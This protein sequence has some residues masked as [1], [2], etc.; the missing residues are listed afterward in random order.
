MLDSYNTENIPY[1]TCAT[2]AIPGNLSFSSWNHG[3]AIINC[4]GNGLDFEG[5]A[6]NLEFQGL[7]ILDTFLKVNDISLTVNNC[8]FG[9]LLQNTAF[10]YLIHV[11]VNNPL[12]NF[13][14]YISS[15]NFLEGNMAGVLHVINYQ[16]VPL[17]VEI[18]NTTV[19]NN[20]LKGANYVIFI[21]GYVNF[22]FMNS[23]ISNTKFLETIS[24]RSLIYFDGCPYTATREAYNDTS[25]K[26]LGTKTTQMKS[27]QHGEP[28]DPELGS[29]FDNNSTMLSFNIKGLNVSDNHAGII[30][31]LF[32]ASANVSVT[33]STFLNN[34]NR[35]LLDGS[36]VIYAKRKSVSLDI[37]VEN[38]SFVANVNENTGPLVSINVINV[39][40]IV[41]N[42]TFRHNKGGAVYVSASPGSKITIRNSSVQF[43]KSFSH[44]MSHCGAQICVMFRNPVSYVS[45]AKEYDSPSS[46][47]IEMGK[48]RKM[49]MY[50]STDGSRKPG[51]E[52]NSRIHRPVKRDNVEN[53]KFLKMN[54]SF[55]HDQTKTFKSMKQGF[56]LERSAPLKVNAGNSESS[57]LS[58]LEYREIF[59][60]DLLVEDCY[61]NNNTGFFSSSAALEVH[62]EPYISLGG[63]SVAKVCIR[64]CKFVG[65]AAKDGSGAIYVAVNINFSISNSIFQD[66]AGASSGAVYFCGSTMVIYNCTLDNNSGGFTVYTQA[67]GSVRLGRKGTALMQDSRIIQR[68]IVRTVPNMGIYH[69]SLT[70]STDSFDKIVLSNSVLDCQWSPSSEKVIVL[71]LAHTRRFVLKKGTSIQCPRGYKTKRRTISESEQSFECELCTKGTYSIDRGIYR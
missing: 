7:R 12:S 68:N 6:T 36:V 39:N 42:C 71:E 24:E 70:V 48:L 30:E 16:S 18:R 25:V 28:V 41:I 63:N 58:S 15:L 53:G 44:V 5:N 27:S 3:S 20:Y 35:W 2:W 17:I 60:S 59:E 4:S 22:I 13:K 61:F 65:N 11:S 49:Y 55:I 51:F 33:D 54:E 29:I 8:S 64:R 69:S 67:T 31:T 45:Q 21:E 47:A 19:T 32:C 50:M 66:N 34:T 43:S 9:S 56:R 46:H 57:T 52:G 10:L 37:L 38:S 26:R 62:S 40:I 14:I 23:E 1:D